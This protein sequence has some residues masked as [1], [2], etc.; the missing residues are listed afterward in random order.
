MRLLLLLMPMAAGGGMGGG[1]KSLSISTRQVE[2][3]LLE[4]GSGLNLLVRNCCILS[5]SFQKSA[6]ADDPHAIEGC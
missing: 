1:G 4:W 2:S 6:G 5:S 3:F